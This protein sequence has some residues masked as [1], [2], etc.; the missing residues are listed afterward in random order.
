MLNG[1]AVIT[2]HVSARPHPDDAE[3]LHPALFPM[4]EIFRLLIEL[5]G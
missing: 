3:L 5:I 2:H 1:L 4:D